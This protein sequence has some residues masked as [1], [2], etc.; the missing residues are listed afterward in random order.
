MAPTDT[1]STPSFSCTNKK[2]KETFL[3]YYY[4]INMHCRNTV[5]WRSLSMTGLSAC[6]HGIR[7]TIP[8]K[9][10]ATTH[11][12]KEDGENRPLT[13]HAFHC[14][15]IPWGCLHSCPIKAPLV[16]PISPGGLHTY[17]SKWMC[18]FKLHLCI[19]RGT[20]PAK[21]GFCIFSTVWTK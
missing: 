8:Y 2:T 7:W 21:G 19:T 16:Q 3:P 13:A 12:G 15:S 10:H 11:I 17:L 6:L 14:T 18:V 1:A 20:R 9:I 4:N 5:M